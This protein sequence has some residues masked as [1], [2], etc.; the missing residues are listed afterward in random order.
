MYM[1]LQT[2]NL[3]LGYLWQQWQSQV[4]LGINL[5]ARH[6]ILLEVFPILLSRIVQAQRGWI[7]ECWCTDIFRSLQRY[8]IGFRA[9]LWLGHSRIFTEFSQSHSWVFL[10]VCFGFLSCWNIHF[11]PSLRSWK[12][13]VSLRM[14]LYCALYLSWCCHHC[15]RL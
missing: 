6:T 8:S 12:L 5:Q 11:H 9:G 3:A 13:L 4:F 7:W 14:A 15:A 2:F 1:S 10:V